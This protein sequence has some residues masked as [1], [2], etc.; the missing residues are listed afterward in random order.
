MAGQPR[1]LE[2]PVEIVSTPPPQTWMNALIEWIAARIK[3]GGGFDV[4]AL[5]REL[6]DQY[7]SSLFETPG[8]LLE[9]TSC[10]ATAPR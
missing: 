6:R 1:S 7:L 5:K 2:W 8:D 4:D 10:A 3:P 9:S